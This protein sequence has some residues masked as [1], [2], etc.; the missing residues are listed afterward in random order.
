MGYDASLSIVCGARLSDI[1]PEGVTKVISTV[2]RTDGFGTLIC[3]FQLTEYFLGSICVGN[4][5]SGS[6]KIKLADALDSTGDD[7][8]NEGWLHYSDYECGLPDEWI[9]G[10]LIAASST[11]NVL[12]LP[13]V[14]YIET[15][16]PEVSRFLLD[17][18][19]YAGDVECFAVLNHSC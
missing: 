6:A 3:Q 11:K 2:Q 17:R 13:T 18:F 12:L 9:V 15:F 8:E 16:E 7:E 10:R 1:F 5:K 19:Q 14:E 4:N